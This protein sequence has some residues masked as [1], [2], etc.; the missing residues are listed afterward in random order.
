MFNSSFIR[1]ESQECEINLSTSIFV[2]LE[3]VKNLN[4]LLL[5]YSPDDA[6]TL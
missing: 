6:V 5:K 1:V 4:M 2:T 3:A